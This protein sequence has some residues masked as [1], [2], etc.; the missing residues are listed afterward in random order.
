MTREV[1][2]PVGQEQPRV[3]ETGS[4]RGCS[5]NFTELDSGRNAFPYRFAET[6]VAARSY[7]GAPRRPICNQRTTSDPIHLSIPDKSA[8]CSKKQLQPRDRRGSRTSF[9]DHPTARVRRG[10]WSVGRSVD[11]VRGRRS[12]VNCPCL[13][14]IPAIDCAV[15]AGGRNGD[16]DV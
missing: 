14:A 2:R 8:C 1:S 4:A 7:A 5:K 11:A 15:P 3:R 9:P 13:S 10:K 6:E 16:W 12:A